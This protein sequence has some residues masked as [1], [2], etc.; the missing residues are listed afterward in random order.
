MALRRCA[1]VSAW[2]SP[3]SSSGSDGPSGC[4]L[5]SSRVKVGVVGL[6]TMGGGVAKR[7]LEAGHTVHGWNRT[8]SK[9]QWLLDL[10]LQ[11]ADSPVSEHLEVAHDGDQRVAKV[12]GND[13][14]ELLQLVVRAS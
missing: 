6:G 5:G 12:V 8:K 14:G 3:G 10:G 13:F 4:A 7:L 2:R 11:W 1:S 9:A